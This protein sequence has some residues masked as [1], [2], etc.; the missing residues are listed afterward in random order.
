MKKCIKCNSLID[1]NVLSCPICGFDFSLCEKCPKCGKEYIGFSYFCSY[2]GNPLYNNAV[3]P[4]KPPVGK[5]SEKSVFSEKNSINTLS[6]SSMNSKSGNSEQPTL[7]FEDSLPLDSDDGNHKSS[8]VLNDD[9]DSLN[10]L[11]TNESDTDNDIIVLIDDEAT[12]TNNNDSAK[13]ESDKKQYNR[14]HV[15]FP[16]GKQV[17]TINIK[18]LN[19]VNEPE[20]VEI[21]VE[22]KKHKR[23]LRWKHCLLFL[24]FLLIIA[25]G[26]IGFLYYDNIFNKKTEA[27]NQARTDSLYNVEK[28]KQK[29]IKRNKE[30]EDSILKSQISAIHES[31][32]LEELRKREYRRQD[33]LRVD[34]FMKRVINDVCPE[35]QI[36]ARLLDGENYIYYYTDLSNPI[37][38]LYGFDGVKKETFTI[39]DNIQAKLV[40]SFVTPDRRN[41]IILCKDDKHEYGLAYK[42]DMYESTVADYESMDK[43]GN[44]CFDIGITDDGFFMKFGKGDNNSFKVKYTAYFDKYGNFITQE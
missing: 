1:D 23:R 31:D 27:R 4:Q 19:L 38:V 39:I 20:D 35:N 18:K 7:N 33:S 37:F 10:N 12:D 43:E 32:S 36:L 41:L 30:E 6:D 28:E 42:Y 8:V 14:R 26:I 11:P 34:T 17:K 15:S 21:E 25:A 22:E 3:Q 5:Q 2:C 29:T 13:K 9:N 16:V 40:S 44:K 24:F